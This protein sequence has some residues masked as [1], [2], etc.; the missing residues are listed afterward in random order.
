LFDFLYQFSWCIERDEVS[1]VK[2]ADLV[3]DLCGFFNIV[4][5]VE[6]GFAAFL[7]YGA[8]DEFPDAAR[9]NDI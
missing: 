3:A 2:D 5:G 8:F 1:A 6:D 9:R 4:G 7:A